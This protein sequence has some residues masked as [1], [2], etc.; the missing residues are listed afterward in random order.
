MNK[1]WEFNILAIIGLILSVFLLVEDN[2][3][4]LEVPPQAKNYYNEYISYIPKYC[5]NKVFR[6]NK[7]RISF[8][9]L[10]ED[11]I[12]FCNK[13]FNERQIILDTSFWKWMSIDDKKQLLFHELSHCLINKDH[14]TDPTNY[15]Y[16]T[17]YT[18]PE[19]VVIEQVKE[20]IKYYCE[21]F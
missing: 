5:K 13:T 14:V 18:I 10:G 21:T 15:M 2:V 7:L 6:F 19:K 4:V 11:Y 20:D 17:E 9:P 1:F 8:S 16:P 12:G 3:Q